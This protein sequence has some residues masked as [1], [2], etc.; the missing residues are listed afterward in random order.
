MGW[1]VFEKKEAGACASL[2]RLRAASHSVNFPHI[3]GNP[4]C[5]GKQACE[6][7]I[8]K[9][10]KLALLNCYLSNGG[11]GLRALREAPL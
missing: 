9:L 7:K 6:L 10:T 8:A 3:L 11:R 4:S 2:Q 1:E 5:M